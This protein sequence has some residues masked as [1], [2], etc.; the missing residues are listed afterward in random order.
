LLSLLRLERCSRRFAVSYLGVTNIV[1]TG[2][3]ERK[4]SNQ[5]C[6]TT[7]SINQ[8]HIPNFYYFL[9]N[10]ICV[11]S[12][13]AIFFCRA[14]RN[15]QRFERLTES[16]RLPSES[17]AN[18]RAAARTIIDIPRRRLWPTRP[19]RAQPALVVPGRD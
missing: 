14:D 13:I 4:L 9:H 17:S 1:A 3:E 15:Y 7:Q 18:I 5:I 2:L 12:Q 10:V 6:E 19:H 11:I 16:R 8:F